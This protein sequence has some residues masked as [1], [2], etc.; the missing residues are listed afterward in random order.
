MPVDLTT[1]SKQE[2][3]NLIDN[4]RRKGVTDTPLYLEA[5]RELNRQ[6]APGLDFEKSYRIIIQAAS[7]GRFLSYKD[8]ADESDAAWT[9]VHYAIG[10]HLWDLVEYGHKRG[11]PMLSAIV[12]NKPNVATG[13]MEPETLKGFVGAARALGCEF[14]DD[15]A[16]L[17]KQQQ[18]VF[19]WARTKFDRPA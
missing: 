9:Q 18:E 14:D 7:E 16:F 8:L 1:K 11:W 17:A 10:S 15:E 19:R 12:V 4:H 2:L 6:K 5:L 13:R 3:Q